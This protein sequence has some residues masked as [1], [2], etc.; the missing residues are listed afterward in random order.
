MLKNTK[1]TPA[2]AIDVRAISSAAQADIAAIKCIIDQFLSLNEQ[3]ETEALH[4]AMK[5]LSM[6]SRDLEPLYDVETQTDPDHFPNYCRESLAAF[7]LVSNLP[8]NERKRAVAVF[9]GVLAG[10][11]GAQS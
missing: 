10:I 2:K 4:G 6:L 9:R 7:E 5:L 8:K 1:I 3:P 11:E